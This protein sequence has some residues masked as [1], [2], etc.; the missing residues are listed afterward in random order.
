MDEILIPLKDLAKEATIPQLKYWAK[1]LSILLIVRGRVAHV[2]SDD[3]Q[4][5][6][7]IAELVKEGKSPQD[8]AEVVGVVNR[9][10][11]PSAET[12]NRS[13]IFDLKEKIDRLERRNEGIENA[14][15][16]VVEEMRNL[17]QENSALKQYL[18]P[19]PEPAKVIIPWQPEPPKDPLEGLT[20]VQRAYV[21]VFE[22]QKMRKFDV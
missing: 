14:L 20:W 5:L 12:N 3:A 18:M 11:I 19:P 9:E 1:L 10:I 15:L 2:N 16:A 7:K 13:G 8:A 17:R 4:K 22:P 21:Q 6:L